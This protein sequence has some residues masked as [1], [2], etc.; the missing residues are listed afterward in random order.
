MTEEWHPTISQ[1][2]NERKQREKHL[3]LHEGLKS[4]SKQ[5]AAAQNSFASLKAASGLSLLKWAKKSYDAAF[6]KLFVR[7]R[8]AVR[9]FKEREQWS[10]ALEKSKEE[11]FREDTTESQIVSKSREEEWSLSRDKSATQ[12][13]IQMILLELDHDKPHNQSFRKQE[14]VREEKAMLEDLKKR[15]QGVESDINALSEKCMNYRT[16]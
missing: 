3:K 9:D 8:R 6:K 11:A 2:G 5:L 13:E 12:D 1:Y 14:N 15:L 7:C 4:L 10:S 16:E